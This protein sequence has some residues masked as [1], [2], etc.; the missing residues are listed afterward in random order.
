MQALPLAPTPLL[1]STS[2]TTFTCLPSS[3]AAHSKTAESKHRSRDND[4][5]RRK[6]KQQK[7]KNS[8]KQNRLRYS[9]A[10][11]QVA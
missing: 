10:W 11:S 4:T 5:G 1:R 9:G 3:W 2:E 8:N 6:K 7:Q